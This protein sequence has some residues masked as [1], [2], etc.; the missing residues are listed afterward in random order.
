MVTSDILSIIALAL[1]FLSIAYTISVDIRSRRTVRIQNELN[2]KLL[3][4]E[5][6]EESKRNK[7]EVNASFF[8]GFNNTWTLRIFNKGNSIAR[9][10]NWSFVGEEPGWMFHRNVFP[11][12]F[13]NPGQ[14]I[15]M[16]ASIFFGNKGTAKIEITWEDDS[17]KANKWESIIST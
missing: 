9:N 6:D 7:A 15:D 13:L 16:N 8:K 3:A 14:N 12:E 2:T 4:K 17:S 11:L 10:V 5:V 1:T